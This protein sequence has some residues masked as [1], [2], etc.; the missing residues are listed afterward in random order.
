MA[1]LRPLTF[2]IETVRLPHTFFIR[3]TWRETKAEVNFLLRSGLTR[4]GTMVPKNWY[5]KEWDRQSY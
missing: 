4:S 1:T 5:S 2:D 3:A